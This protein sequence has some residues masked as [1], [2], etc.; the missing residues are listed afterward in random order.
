MR[1]GYTIL[2]VGDVAASVDFY[3]RAF[4][5][6]PRFVHE[7]GQYAELETGQTA[8]SFASYELA[9]QNVP[10]LSPA[11]DDNQPP[12][13]EVCLVTDDVTGAWNRAVEAGATGVS[14][15]ETKPWGQQ[16][17]YVRDPDGN[18]IEIASPAT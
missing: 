18:L 7:S 9:D 15:P 3:G 10:G 14:E 6:K 8:L 17:S 4:G 5:L 11:R 13:F 12:S 16:T 1:F 2:Y